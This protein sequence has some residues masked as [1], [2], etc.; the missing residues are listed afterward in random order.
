[1]QVFEGS[2]Y[3][4]AVKKHQRY[5][6]IVISAESNSYPSSR[7]VC[8]AA[9]RNCASVASFESAQYLRITSSPDEMRTSHLDFA[10][11]HETS[12]RSARMTTS[13][14]AHSRLNKPPPG[15]GISNPYRR[16]IPCTK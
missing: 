2:A 1:M 4:R 6:R 14:R 3:L 16:A 5:R 11:S 13:I 8:S 15:S 7:T 10:G 9:D 12:A